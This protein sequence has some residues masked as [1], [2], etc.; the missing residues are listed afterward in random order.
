MKKY[1]ILSLLILGLFASCTLGSISDEDNIN[2]IIADYQDIL[3]AG[4][5][6]SI[7]DDTKSEINTFFWY[8]ERAEDGTSF[9]TEITMDGDS[10]F[11]EISIELDGYL[12]IAYLTDSL[13]TAYL[14]KPFID[15]LI[16]YAVF[17]KDTNRNYHGGWRL[18]ELTCGAIYAQP[19][20]SANL[21]IDSIHIYADNIIDTVIIDID[22]FFSRDDIMELP[23]SADITID[24]YSAN[25]DNIFFIHSNMK[26][27]RAYINNGIYSSTW[28]VP[29]KSGIY[30]CIV[31]G[32]HFNALN[33]DGAEY[34]CC[35]WIFPYRAI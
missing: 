8:R 31:D 24:I 7:E 17:K 3:I 14:S 35:A 6:F 12:N 23:V 11:A 27:S 9:L 34:D 5:S 33:D 29:D 16:R 1:T 25:T 2:L 15:T 30:R 13:D 28:T 4:F 32:M 18:D 20:D 26:R 19:T 22:D 10:A 21:N